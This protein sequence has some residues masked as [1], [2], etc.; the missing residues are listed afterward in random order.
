MTEGFQI[1][2]A[3]ASEA[4]VV[5][6]F[7]IALLEELF[8]REAGS[9]DE[10][11]FTEVTEKLLKGHPGVW[12]L[13]AIAESGEPAGILTLSECA[14]IYAG[15]IFGE[16]AEIYVCPE[17]RSSGLGTRLLDAAVAFGH[18][19]QWKRLEVGA[20]DVPRWSRTMDFYLGYG[21]SE[22]GPRLSYR[23]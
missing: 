1:R 20:P 2:M 8:P 17:H 3:E 16:I 22:I 13:L 21:F 4:G 9:F 15:G 12:A 11:A 14:A 6:R 7:V 19:R 10:R 5:A 18:N 23:L